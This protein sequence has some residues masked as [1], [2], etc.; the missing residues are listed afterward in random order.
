ML[1]ILIPTYNYNITSLVKKIHEEVEK[2]D[3]DFEIKVLDDC[4]PNVVLENE[5]I[6]NFRN[7]TFTRLDKNLGRTAIRNLLAK[8]AQ[9]NWLLFLDA[10]VLPKHSNFIQTYLENCENSS[11]DVIYGG[12][13]YQKKAPSKHKYLRWHYGRKREAKS[14]AERNKDP[15]FIISQN[16]FIK[17]KVFLSA[18][19]NEE[20]HY[21]LDNLFSNQLKKLEVKVRHIDNPVIHLGIEDSESFIQK[22]KKAVETTVIFERRGLMDDNLRPLQKSYLRLK[23][24]RATQVFSFCISP[25]KKLMERNFK[26]ENPHLFWFDLYRLN[27]YIELKSKQRA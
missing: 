14:V 11:A 1:S 5:Q 20:N 13:S 8:N 12:I 6:T 25:F 19:I 3:V 9:Y 18:N 10:D 27:Y 4:S 17:K 22:A 16:L 23:K 21:G 15:Y 24:Y 26:S 7:T 2:L